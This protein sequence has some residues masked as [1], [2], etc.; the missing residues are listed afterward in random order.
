MKLNYHKKINQKG[1]RHLIFP[2]MFNLSLPHS[3]ILSDIRLICTL[4]SL[5]DCCKSSFPNMGP[6]RTQWAHIHGCVHS[7]RRPCLTR[8]SRPR[9]DVLL[10]TLSSTNRLMPP[11][12]G[13]SKGGSNFYQ[14]HDSQTSSRSQFYICE[15]GML[16]FTIQH[17]VRIN[18]DI[19]R[20]LHVFI[21]PW[22]STCTFFFLE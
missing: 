13:K 20:G 15:M 12:E 16:I 17:C 22:F 5:G 2:S 1:F 14:L 7:G 8:G 3:H 4:E 18:H 11:K 19:S 6:Q 9:V 21:P 10:H